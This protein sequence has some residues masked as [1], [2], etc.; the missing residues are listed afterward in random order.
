MIPKSHYRTWVPALVLEPIDASMRYTIPSTLNLS[1]RT[2]RFGY[3]HSK[4]RCLAAIYFS[5]SV[6]LLNLAHAERADIIHRPASTEFR[7]YSNLLLLLF[8]LLLF[9][10]RFHFRSFQKLF[11]HDNTVK[12]CHSKKMLERFV[13]NPAYPSWHPTILNPTPHLVGA[14]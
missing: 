14:K 9:L 5:I 6:Y 3:G 13:V 12:Q 1:P 11:L 8:L 7:S 10:V 4:S 2:V